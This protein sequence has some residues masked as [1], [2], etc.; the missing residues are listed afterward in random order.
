MKEKI[1]MVL[2]FTFVGIFVSALQWEYLETTL[3]SQYF[4]TINDLLLRKTKLERENSALKK[5]LIME[6]I[7]D[8][9]V[10]VRNKD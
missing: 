5:Q 1:I 6:A 3:R 10:N 9:D 7:G 8:K 2:V 4:S